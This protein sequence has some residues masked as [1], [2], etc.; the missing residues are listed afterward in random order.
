MSP[1]AK[2]AS[3]LAPHSTLRHAWHL[4]GGVSAEVTAL[5]IQ[6]ADG[7]IQKVVVRRHG[8]VD[9]Q[10][11]PQIAAHE[12]TL[13]T[14]LQRA[15]IPIPAPLA[16]DV[17][18]TILPT[19]YLVVEFIEGTSEIAAPALSEAIPQIANHLAAIHRV[20]GA[21]EALTFLPQQT[22]RLARMLQTR[23]TL[24]DESLSEGRIRQ[25]LDGA[26]PLVQQNPSVLLHG[27][28]WQG[29]L[30]WNGGQLTAILDW[31]DAAVGDPLAD[32]GNARLELLWAFGKEAMDQFTYHYRAIMPLDNTQLP[33]WD[34]VAALRPA[35]KLGNWGLD[36]TT[37]TSMRD[38][39]H[40]FVDQAVGQLTV[41]S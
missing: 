8:V 31:E 25:V 13:L 37:E 18:C 24:P 34:L 19:P 20:E 26:M 38:K 32:V 35:G 11:N 22:E 17:S 39:H 10:A 9:L 23:P 36:A 27:D 5:E 29:N 1:F 4:A 3:L 7:T 6:R 12:F 30:L 2:I 16:L 41:D 28:Y 40:W 15:G 33:Y 21:V 14:H